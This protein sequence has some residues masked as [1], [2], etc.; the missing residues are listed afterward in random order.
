MIGNDIVDLKYIKE[1]SNWKR[2]RF[3][4][5]VFTTKEQHL[6]LSSEN[7]HQMVW[8][9]WSMKEAAYKCH[10]QQY[11]RRFFNPKRLVCELI[12]EDKGQVNIDAIQY[13]TATIVTKDYVYT[14]AKQTDDQPVET[15]IIETKAPKLATQSVLLKRYALESIAEVKHLDLDMLEIR[16]TKIGAPEVYYASQKTPIDLTLTH[17][18]RFSSF[19]F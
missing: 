1:T 14:I 3:L 9:L 13:Y 19:A 7:Q 17:C 16:K 12:S 8:L 18:G 6:I 15:S 10:V 2:P 5:K 4:D 11:G